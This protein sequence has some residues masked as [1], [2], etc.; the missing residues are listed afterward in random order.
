MPLPAAH[1]DVLRARL[2]EL[3]DWAVQLRP[4]HAH[5]DHPSEIHGLSHTTRVMFHVLLLGFAGGLDEA[6]VRRTFAAAVIHDQARTHDGWCTLHGAW[7]RE[8]KLPKWTGRFLGAGLNDEDLELVADA[9]EFHCLDDLPRDHAAYPTMALL[10]DADALDRYRLGPNGLNM[11]F[12]RHAHAPA[13]AP[14]AA[15]LV[16]HHWDVEH[17]EDLRASV[18]G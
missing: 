4:T 13:F 12:L 8:E 11:R 1:A 2:V 7:S 16:R 10:K 18:L 5:F 9:V 3:P 14:L 6:L 15:H 17:L